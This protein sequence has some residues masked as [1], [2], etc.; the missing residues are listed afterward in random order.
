MSRFL[1]HFF[2][3]SL[4]MHVASAVFKRM[5]VKIISVL[6]G[7][8]QKLDKIKSGIR[9]QAVDELQID[10]SE[11]PGDEVHNLK[12]HG[13][14]HRVVH[15]YT[16]EHYQHLIAKF[17]DIADR[18]IPGSYGENIYTKGLTETDLCIGD[19]FSMGTAKVQVTASRQPCATI[20]RSYED[21]RVLKE[22]MKSGR[23]G[24]F[25]RVLK[26]GIV[27]P[28]DYLELLERPFPN[29]KLDRLFTEGFGKE[30][31]L[32]FLRACLDTG[33][34]DK[35]WQPLLE[36]L[37]VGHMKAL[38]LTQPWASLITDHG[39]N[40]ENRTW[41]TKHRGFFAIHATKTYREEEFNFCR[42]AFKI[43][44]A[45]ENTPFGAIIGFAELTSTITAEEVTSKT[46][47]WFLGDYG[48]VMQNI[49]KLK[50]PVPT[51][52]SL[53][54]WDVDAQTLKKCLEQLSPQER[55]LVLQV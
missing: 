35:G 23:T 3:F 17:P 2:S 37:F 41:N 7:R 20:N 50:T 27:R 54:F 51:K 39:M 18:F 44:L 34:M 11:I 1:P 36:S 48:F 52:G 47:K 9:N 10:L 38:S 21:N 8:V 5:K 28:G 49:I 29:L 15:H 42:Q 16:E 32:S 25:Y 43:K 22:I 30:K 40:V 55:K 13:G 46:R 14:D 24:W 53:S 26:P 33:L 45:P 12:Y 19:I 6:R 31:D 4:R